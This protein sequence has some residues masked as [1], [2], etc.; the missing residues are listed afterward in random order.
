ME[1]LKTVSNSNHNPEEKC[2]M[3]KVISYKTVAVLDISGTG[4]VVDFSPPPNAPT[5]FAT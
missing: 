3:N 1:V 5:L 2:E 4:P